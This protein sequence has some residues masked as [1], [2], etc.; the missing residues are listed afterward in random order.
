MLIINIEKSIN[1]IHIIVKN[2]IY[3]YIDRIQSTYLNKVNSALLFSGHINEN[4][5][6]Q[7]GINYQINKFSS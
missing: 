2:L 6:F 7:I 1:I 5:K 4:T 3:I